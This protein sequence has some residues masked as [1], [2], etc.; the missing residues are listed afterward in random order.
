MTSSNMKITRNSEYGDYWINGDGSQWGP[1]YTRDEAVD[2]A[3]YLNDSASGVFEF[4]DAD[5][6]L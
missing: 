5:P 3:R 6:G 2:H 1:F 4:I